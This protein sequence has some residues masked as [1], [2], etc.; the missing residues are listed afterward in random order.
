MTAANGGVCALLQ[1]QCCFYINNS[2]DLEARQRIQ[3]QA[4]SSGWTL[5]SLLPHLPPHVPPSSLEP[6]T[7]LYPVFKTRHRSSSW[8]SRSTTQD[9]VQK[10]LLL[11]LDHTPELQNG[12]PSANRK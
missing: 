9:V 3:Q 1:E 5:G 7:P 4:S 12:A 2:K 10:M 8:I 6:H 11:E